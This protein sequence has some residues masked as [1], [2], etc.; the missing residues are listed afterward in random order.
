MYRAP[1]ISIL[2]FLSQVRVIVDLLGTPTEAGL[3]MIEV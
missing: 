3:M 2:V 1:G